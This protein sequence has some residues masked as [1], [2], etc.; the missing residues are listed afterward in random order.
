MSHETG[1]SYGRILKSSA[2]LGG[3][4][5][6]NVGLAALRTK[7]LAVW[8][9]P[10]LFGTMGLYMA[11]IAMI[12]A[13]ASLGLGQSAVRDI[14]EAAGSGDE[15]RIARTIRAYRRIVWITGVGG[16]LLTAAL[17][18][19]LSYLTFGDPAHAWPIAALSLV[20]LFAQL[21]AGQGALV[22]GMR[23]I[24]DMTAITITGAMGATLVAVPLILWFKQNAI[25]PLL[26]GVAA[27]QLSATSWYARRIHVSKVNLAWGETWQI[28]RPM[29]A[30]GLTFVLLGLLAAGSAY[31]VRLIIQRWEGEASVG[32]YHAAFALSGIYVGFILQ[33]MGGDYYPRLAGAVNDVKGRNRLVNEQ[34]EV[35]LLLAAPA[36]VAALVFSDWIIAALYSPDFLQASAVLRWH[37]LGM[38]GRIVSWPLGYLLL[39]RADKRAVAV[40]EVTA[41]VAHVGLALIGVATFGAIGAGVAF[42]AMYVLHSVIVVWVARVRHAF[43]WRQ[44]GIRTLV[45]STL[46]VTVAF[47]STYFA[48]SSWRL[49]VGTLVLAAA[50]ASCTRRL[51]SRLGLNGGALPDRGLVRETKSP[52]SLVVTT[53]STT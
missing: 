51:V 15:M 42:A 33:A 20:V 36:L 8:L 17:A 26:L 24:G 31:L 11:T 48:D 30:L 6:V 19:P 27:V 22:Q 47:G 41:G 21:Q 9:G 16:M 46:L 23:R 40:T 52:D 34:A 53:G 7:L 10:A 35:A 50:V 37:V 28:V 25:V 4:S 5:V 38:L 12:A 18:L 1:S 45:L 49:T 14:A 2:L 3:S 43:E 32:L 29:V 44:S 39:A 13:L